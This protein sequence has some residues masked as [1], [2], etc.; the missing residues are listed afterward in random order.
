MGMIAK[1]IGFLLILL[2][3]A[4]LGIVLV[5]WSSLEEQQ[6]SEETEQASATGNDS[7]PPEVA[8]VNEPNAVDTLPVPV[9]GSEAVPAN[10]PEPAAVDNT[11]LTPANNLEPMPAGDTEKTIRPTKPENPLAIAEVD[12]GNVEVFRSHRSGIIRYVT[13]GRYYSRQ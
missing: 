12:S 13:I 7:V 11:E 1:S 10:R 3:V 9:E 5:D 2:G 6:A 8:A 4:G